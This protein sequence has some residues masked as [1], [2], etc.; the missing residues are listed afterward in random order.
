MVWYDRPPHTSCLNISLHF[1]IL[2]RDK[3]LAL[4]SHNKQNPFWKRHCEGMRK[5]YHASRGVK[6]C[7]QAR[8]RKSKCL[9]RIIIRCMR[10]TIPEAIHATLDV[11]LLGPAVYCV[12]SF[13]FLIYF[14]TYAG[15]LHAYGQAYW[16]QGENIFCR[17]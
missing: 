15:V 16:R 17:T 13:L 11:L 5:C 6:M 1:V 4:Q 2:G 12:I 14:H 10:S 3:W 7:G 9:N 8:Q